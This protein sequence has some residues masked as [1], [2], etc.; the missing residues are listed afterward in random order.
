MFWYLPFSP[1]C[2]STSSKSIELIFPA[3]PRFCRVSTVW[4]RRCGLRQRR[5]RRRRRRRSCTMRRW[6]GTPSNYTAWPPSLILEG[7]HAELQ[8]HVS[9]PLRPRPRTEEASSFLALP[10]SSPPPPPP[11]PLPP[12]PPSPPFSPRSP[13]L[14]PRPPA[15]PLPPYDVPPSVSNRA[16]LKAISTIWARA[17]M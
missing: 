10:P 15:V 9:R 17:T 12:P 6:C 13:R 8:T 2:T 4:P 11:P 1:T 3:M 16:V 7:N 14:P 5:R